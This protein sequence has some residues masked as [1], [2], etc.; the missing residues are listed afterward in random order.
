MLGEVTHERPVAAV[1]EAGHAMLHVGDEALP[2][3]LAVV[4]DV[5]ADL[6]LRGDRRGGRLRDRGRQLV[7]VHDL[8]AAPAPV[9][10]G[11]RLG[12][13]QAACVGDEDAALAREHAAVSR[14]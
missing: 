8:A 10:L 7:V 2:C 14:S 12:A 1:T 13:R 9:E 6:A 3:L 4:A 11:E 5:D